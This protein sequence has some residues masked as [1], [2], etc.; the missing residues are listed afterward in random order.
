VTVVSAFLALLSGFLVIAVILGILT[1]LFAHFVPEWA[2]AEARPRPGYV[3]VNLGASFLAAGAGGYVTAVV[4]RGN[5]LVLDLALAV[6]V[7]MLAA[8]STLQSR[9]K[10]PIWYQLALVAITPLG[11]FAGGIVRMKILGIL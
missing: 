6:I 4:A 3:F 2:S 10:Q 5:P 9:G 11:V 7:L 1:A 8:L